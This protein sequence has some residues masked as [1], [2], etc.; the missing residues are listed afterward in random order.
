MYWLLGD[1]DTLVSF[2]APLLDETESATARMESN[3]IAG[4]V[5]FGLRGSF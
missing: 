3:N 1:R 5:G 4:Q 2:T